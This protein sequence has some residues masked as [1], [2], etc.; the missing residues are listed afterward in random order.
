MCVKLISR[1]SLKI[2][3][4]LSPPR[5]WR[6]NLNCYSNLGQ[7]GVN[8]ISFSLLWRREVRKAHHGEDKEMLGEERDGC[9]GDNS[10]P[11]NCDISISAR[12]PFDGF[13]L[14]RTILI[15]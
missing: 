9:E 7:P 11:Q 12:Q 6:H 13:R 8:I 15:S 5:P 2:S 14:N 4:C 1:I 3:V 10:L